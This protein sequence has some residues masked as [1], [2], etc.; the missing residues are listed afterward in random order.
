MWVQTK[1]VCTWKK[2]HCTFFAPRM[3]VHLDYMY[4]RPSAFDQGFS[5]TEA[6]VTDNKSVCFKLSSYRIVYQHLK[7]FPHQFS[8]S[9]C[10]GFVPKFFRQSHIVTT[11]TLKLIG[12]VCRGDKVC[13]IWTFLKN[14]WMH[15]SQHGSRL[16]ACAI[17]VTCATIKTTSSYAV[18]ELQLLSETVVELWTSVHLLLRYSPLYNA[19]EAFV[20][21]FLIFLVF[22]CCSSVFFG[23]TFKRN[24]I[25]CG[26]HWPT[27]QSSTFGTAADRCFRFR[28]AHAQSPRQPQLHSCGGLRVHTPVCPKIWTIIPI[29]TIHRIALY[30]CRLSPCSSMCPFGTEI[31]TFSFSIRSTTIITII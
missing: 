19:L 20:S 21:R 7:P 5:L 31:N 27:S 8:T 25:G 2:W 18:W 30:D 15:G 16:H 9:K 4:C 1:W 10:R 24:W 23:L 6:D 26:F 14:V 28:E 17:L 3:D 29:W 22:K 12:Q 11:P 13:R